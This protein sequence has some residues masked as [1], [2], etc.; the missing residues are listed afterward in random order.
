MKISCDQAQFPSSLSN[1]PEYDYKNF[2]FNIYFYQKLFSMLYVLKDSMRALRTHG[3]TGILDCCR[4]SIRFRNLTGR[5]RSTHKSFKRSSFSTPA[6]KNLVWN[7]PHY[8]VFGNWLSFFVT[9]PDKY[10]LLP[11]FSSKTYS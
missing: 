2:V 3:F 1:I 10:L 4:V 9:H 8:K 5:F 7:W 6:S 11:E